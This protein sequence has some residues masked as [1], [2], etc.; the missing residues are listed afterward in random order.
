VPE[1][2]RVGRSWQA[3]ASSGNAVVRRARWEVQERTLIDF[4]RELLPT[5]AEIQATLKGGS[6]FV[7]SARYR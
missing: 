5:V 4:P 6:E 2:R 1:K 7:Q 3:L